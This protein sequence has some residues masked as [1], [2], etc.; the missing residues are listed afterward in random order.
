VISLRNSC[1]GL[2]PVHFFQ[3]LSGVAIGLMVAAAPLAAVPA[4]AAPRLAQPAL[5][6][7]V[8]AFYNARNGAPLWF[9]ATSGGA[10]QALVEQL[11]SARTDGLDPQRYGVDALDNALREA[12]GGKRKAVQRAD[13]ML[14]QA[15]VAYVSDLEQAPDL[16][17]IYVDPQLKRSTP[18]ASAILGQAAAALCRVRTVRPAVR[19]I[20]LQRRIRA[21]A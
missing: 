7:G 19:T 2:R 5:G 8:G 15:F 12:A 17:I 6:T 20:P 16:G 11:K 1:T 4:G 10:A 13:A 3:K 21:R 14:S 9:S 18:T